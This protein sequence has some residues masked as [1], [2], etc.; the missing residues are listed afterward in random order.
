AAHFDEILPLLRRAFSEFTPPEREKMLRLA[1]RGMQEPEKNDASVETAF[2]Q[3][4]AKQVLP[5]V[6]LLLG[7]D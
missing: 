5:T 6:K 1:R 3:K 4:R 7:L 2:D